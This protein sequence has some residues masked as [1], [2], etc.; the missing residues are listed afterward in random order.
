MDYLHTNFKTLKGADFSSIDK[1]LTIS[2][3]VEFFRQIVGSI[4]IRNLRNA[5]FWK[6]AT[7]S[8]CR[9]H[10]YFVCQE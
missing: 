2:Y 5:L 8:H 10:T 4:F 3:I 6:L 9:L 1:T 7:R